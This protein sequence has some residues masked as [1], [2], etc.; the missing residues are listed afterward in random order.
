MKISNA[1]KIVTWGPCPQGKARIVVS[2]MITNVHTPL[3]KGSNNNED[4]DDLD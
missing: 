1:G 2:G 4:L 3:E